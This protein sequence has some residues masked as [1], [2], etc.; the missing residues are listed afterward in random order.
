MMH[1]SLSGIL[2]SGMTRIQES[3][4]SE[5]CLLFSAVWRVLVQARGAVTPVYHH[6]KDKTT[7]DG[8]AERRDKP[9]IL[10]LKDVRSQNT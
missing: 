6:V 2:W 7:Q 5:I 1:C 9:S 3:G 8:K 4:Y 10:G